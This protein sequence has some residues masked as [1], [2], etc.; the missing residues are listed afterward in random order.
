M[1][2]CNRIEDRPQELRKEMNEGFDR[3]NERFDTIY[4]RMTSL[5]KW[6]VGT[7]MNILLTTGQFLK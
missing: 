2:G 3:I 6:R 4:E 7:I 5:V 1:F